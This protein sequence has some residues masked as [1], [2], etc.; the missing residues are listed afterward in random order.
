M[1]IPPADIKWFS[2]RFSDACRDLQE[3]WQL[4]GAPEVSDEPNPHELS[5]A[6]EQLLAL[7]DRCDAETASRG[8]L[9]MPDG[10]ELSDLGD[11]GL[12][13]LDNLAEITSDLGLAPEKYPW[14]ELAVSLSLWLIRQGAEITTLGMLINGLAL[15]ANKTMDAWQLEALYGVMEEVFEATLP[16]VREE[17]LYTDTKHPWR[18]LIINRA[19]V[20]TRA[21]S[22]KLMEQ[23]FSAISEYL[24]EE[25]PAFFQEGLEQ[26]ELHR[27]PEEVCEV[28]RRFY[29]DAT[30]SRTLH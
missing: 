25:A 30:A 28:I 14:E 3:E 4:H 12:A 21:L 16:S 20:A 23:A 29:S 1:D 26:M 19:I 15:I 17:L 6:M 8:E 9:R 18:L 7:F 13:I 5:E 11:Y 10:L 27:M 22:P 24:P 2:A